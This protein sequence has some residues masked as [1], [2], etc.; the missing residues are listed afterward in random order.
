M[1]ESRHFL[2][3]P[4]PE[5]GHLLPML[6]VARRLRQAGHTVR[7]LIASP[8]RSFLA[9]EG[10]A[11]DSYT[12]SSCSD[13]E[14]TMLNP[15]I[16]GRALWRR[17]WEAGPK[18][19][20]ADRFLGRL[21]ELA[22][23]RCTQLFVVDS[24]FRDRPASVVARFA[25]DHPV[26]FLATSLPRHSRSRDA[27]PIPTVVLCPRDLL[28]E[29]VVESSE[30]TFFAEPSVD[31]QRP[32]CTADFSFSDPTAPL[33]V[34]NFGSQAG[35]HPEI[36]DRLRILF[37]LAQRRPDLN[38]IAGTGSSS[39][40][41]EPSQPHNL[42]LATSLPQLAL[43]RRATAFITHAG[44]GSVKEAILLGVPMLCWPLCFDQ[45][46]NSEC[47]QAVGA[48]IYSPGEQFS[49]HGLASGLSKLMLL[50]SIRSN[51]AALQSIFQQREATP[52]AHL[53]LQELSYEP[54]RSYSGHSGLA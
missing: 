41:C 11:S 7:F 34:S 18:H 48:G 42:R 44:L 52:V 50:Q 5:A 19:T 27:S 13:Q 35:R 39:L 16:D 2:F 8:F 1:L 45:T 4:A 23:V 54:N 10:F 30:S 3:I 20:T 51:I 6:P 15:A 24:V 26:A 33:I 22:R 38:F 21:Q 31:L 46:F 9:R 32:E 40:L 53:A 28:G 43:L 12:G 36:R 37:A 17:E 14:Q 25:Q 47:V 29:R 49:A